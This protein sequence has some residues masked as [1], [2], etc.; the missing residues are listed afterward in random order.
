MNQDMNTDK[1]IR[2]HT[3]KHPDK[4][5]VERFDRLIGIDAQ[6]RELLD[7]LLGILAPDRVVT[8]ARKH[9]PKGL[10]LVKR[11]ERRSA[12][13]ILAGD[14]GCGKTEIATSVGTPLARALDKR[15]KAFETPSDVRG[16]GLV[17]ELSLR[18]TAAFDLARQELGAD[19]GILIIDE[20]DDLATSREQ[21]QA[22]HEDR[23]GLNVLIKEVDR[24]A[25]DGTALAVILITNRFAALDPA[26][27]RR[28]HIIR[29]SRP[30][31]E[32][33]RRF[34]RE[35]LAGL[36]TSEADV[37]RLVEVTRRDV[38]FTFSD[39][40]SRIAEPALR[41]ALREDRPLTADLILEMAAAAIPSP[42][43]R[44][45]AV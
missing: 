14:V 21:N 17:G 37:E 36:G 34:F 31:E 26:V 23:A 3:T 30:T 7:C 11:F 45:A 19:P 27:V 29:F 10:P 5:A 38:P 18:V 43:F 20:G 22:H 25:V 41:D 13:I 33:R 4:S 12:L 6:K 15:V 35:L 40:L 8:W 1:P 42:I 2:L 24:L 9:H 39:L 28:S 44:D 32:A 16:G